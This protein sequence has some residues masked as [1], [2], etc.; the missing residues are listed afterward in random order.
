MFTVQTT[1][2]QRD[3]PRAEDYELSFNER[4]P[5]FLTVYDGPSYGDDSEKLRVFN[6]RHVVD[7]GWE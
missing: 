1:K 3:F 5:T 2:K 7:Y 6:M 4:G